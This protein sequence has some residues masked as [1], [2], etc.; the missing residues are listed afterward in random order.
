MSYFNDEQ[1]AQLLRP[2]NP[3][4]V[5]SRDGL[6][7]LEAYDVRAHLDRIVGFARWSADLTDLTLLFEAI[8]EKT[9]PA[10]DGKPA[11]T[12]TVVSVGY[13]ATLRLTVCAPDGTA[14]ATYTEAA[15]GDASNFPEVKRADA[16]DFAIKTAESQ[17][18]KRC[19]VNL[20]SQYGLSLY[21]KG[22]LNEIVGKTLMGTT[23]SADTAPVDAH[24]VEVPPESEQVE[25]APDNHTQSTPPAETDDVDARAL[26]VQDLSAQ[27]LAAKN[28][29][30]VSGI[31]IQI[32]KE[33]LGSAL[34]Y[35]QDENA[36]TLAA[37]AEGAL[38]RVMVRGVA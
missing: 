3:R 28:K 19:A 25:P 32:A 8:A 14:L 17:A 23:P 10:K 36:L 21:A 20:G 26:R 31:H 33:K 6:S 24:V 30:E 37:L 29:A 34:T 13:R 9:W 5:N 7:Y 1:L 16:H 22:S 4:R 11:R 15:T 18:L 35:D 38:K 27:L 2:I 12:T